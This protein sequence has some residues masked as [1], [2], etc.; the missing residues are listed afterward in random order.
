MRKQ[1]AERLHTFFSNVLFQRISADY[2]VR[3]I[4]IFN[5]FFALRSYEIGHL[6]SFIL[7]YYASNGGSYFG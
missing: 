5:L 6:R 3:E 1:Y 7:S 2:T 4:C